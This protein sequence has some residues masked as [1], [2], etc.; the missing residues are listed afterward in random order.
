MSSLSV[1]VVSFLGPASASP[2][3]S[4]GLL[5]NF[6][7]WER[8]K[9]ELKSS[10]PLSEGTSEFF[11]NSKHE[12]L[13]FNYPVMNREEENYEQEARRVMYDYL[14]LTDINNFPGKNYR[15]IFFC[16]CRL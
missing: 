5:S 2:V 12:P 16:V 1:G 14:S 11:L 4:Q 6:C 15:R 7:E 13:R 8:L 3:F 10:S 9:S